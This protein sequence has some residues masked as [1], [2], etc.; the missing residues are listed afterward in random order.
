MKIFRESGNEPLNSA[1]GEKK[2]L[3]GRIGN[4]DLL[5]TVSPNRL[6]EIA[7]QNRAMKIWFAKNLNLCTT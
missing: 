4:E 6:S 3:R 5:R 7:L 1:K 2:L